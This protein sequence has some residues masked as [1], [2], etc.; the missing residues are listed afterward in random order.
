MNTEIQRVIQEYYERLNGTKLNNLEEIDKFLDASN[1]P[2]LNHEELENL[3]RP[4]T[5][6][7]IEMVIKNHP[8]IKSRA[9][10]LHQRILPNI[11]RFNTFLLNPF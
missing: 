5:R 11:Q 3:S 7:E 8:K 10:W 4:I 2:I 9:R 6:N 1:L